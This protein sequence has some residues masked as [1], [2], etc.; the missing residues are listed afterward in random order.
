ME[1]R[2][3][4]QRFRSAGDDDVA[5][6]ER[7]LVGR[8]GDRLVRRGAGATHAVRVAPAMQERQTVR[9]RVGADEFIEIFVDTP[10]EICMERD[11]NGLYARARAGEI[12]NFTGVDAT[13]ERPTAADLTID[14]ATSKIGEAAMNVVDLLRRRGIV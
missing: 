2:N 13:Y 1:D 10:I 5:M 6:A 12:P 9:N 4:R 3:I 8:V 7:D 11:P 14:G